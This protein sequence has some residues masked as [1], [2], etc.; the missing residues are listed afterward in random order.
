M[1][2]VQSSFNLYLY[3]ILICTDTTSSPSLHLPSPPSGFSPLCLKFP[4][5]MPPRLLASTLHVSLPFFFQGFLAFS[6]PCFIPP[7]LPPCLMPPRLMPPSSPHVSSPPRITP[8]VPSP[9]LLMPPCLRPLCLPASHLTFITL[10]YIYCPLRPGSAS[11]VLRHVILSVARYKQYIPVNCHRLDTAR[12][13][14][15]R[16]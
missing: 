16:R 14:A 8:H 4:R 5:L 6:P 9:P 11:T 15:F 1:A 13:T 10:F 2:F 12:C 7:R 3:C